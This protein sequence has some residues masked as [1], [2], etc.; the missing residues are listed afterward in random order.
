[1]LD[2]RAR[3]PSATRWRAVVVEARGVALA[4]ELLFVARS[5]GLA[6]HCD[7]GG[8]RVY[9]ASEAAREP[10]RLTPLPCGEFFGFAL[11]GNQRFVL[12]AFQVT[13]NTLEDDEPVVVQLLSGASTQFTSFSVVST[14]VVWDQPQAKAAGKV[15][16]KDSEPLDP[17][18][19]TATFRFKV[20]GGT[21][22][23][24]VTIKFVLQAQINNHAVTIESTPSQPFVVIT[25]E[26]QYEESVLLLMKRQ[27]FSGDSEECAWE[28]LANKLQR[29]FL[30]GTRQDLVKPQRAFSHREV[31][32]IHAKFFNNAPTISLKQLEQFWTWFGPTL[33]KVRYQ[34]HV[35]S[36]WTAGLIYGLIERPECAPHS[37]P[38]GDW[39]L[40]HPLQREPPRLLC[41]RL[42]NL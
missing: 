32:F 38:P 9:I 4:R 10:L 16:L 35:A 12:G 31:S 28:P 1:V 34:R 30:L 22:K 26:C 11:D 25:N 19:R 14:N 24:P 17:T 20:N 15:F 3:K 6:A 29:Q 39:R 37:A 18:T 33:Q 36:M 5:L 8:T 13:H 7:V 40:S 23:L 41:D 27:L 21:R 2:T 42:Q